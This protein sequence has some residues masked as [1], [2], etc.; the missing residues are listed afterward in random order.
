MPRKVSAA[1]ERKAK[2]P[3]LRPVRS[4]A[5]SS[6]QHVDCGSGVRLE[7]GVRL[8]LPDGIELVSDHY[9]PPGTDDG[10]TAPTLLVRQPYG[11]AIA[12]TV[13][14]AQPEWFARHGYNVVIQDVRGRGDSTGKFYPFRNEAGD[15]AFTVEWL[16]QRSETTGRVGMYGFSYQGMTQLLAAAEQPV[17]LTCIAPA[18]T[19]GDLYHGWFYH[20]GALRLAGTVGWAAQMLKTDARRLKLRKASDDLEAVWSK[21]PLLFAHAPYAK[22]SELNARGLPP[23]YHDWVTHREPDDYWAAHDVSRR[24]DRINVPGLHIAGWFDPYLLGSISLYE[25]L[26]AHAGSGHARANQ[27]LVAGPW[28]HIP[29]GR[30]AGE[31]DFGP[32]ANLDTDALLLRWF[33]HWLKDSG[34]FAK[35]PKAK[36]FA[37]GE[38][39]WHSLDEWPTQSRE[40][41]SSAPTKPLANAKSIPPAREEG[42]TGQAKRLSYFLR[43]AGFANSSKGD[44]ILDATAPPT[45]EPRDSFC[46][47][48][49]V[50]VPSPGNGAP[51]QFNQTRAELLNN[52]LIYTG[53][54]VAERLHICGAPRVILFAQTSA[55]STDLVAKL[56]RVTPDGRA[57]NVCL[58]IARSGFLFRDR[59]H[60]PDTPQRWEFTLEPTSCVFAPGERLRLE[61]CSSAFP[62]YDRHP[63]CDV[64]PQRATSWDWRQARTQILH[65]AKHPS[66]L[67]L[68]VLA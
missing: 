17:G 63:N 66:S 60:Q 23:Y 24:Y 36:L 37:Q 27:F 6:G 45:D 47:E 58:G 59:P 10:R 50:P 62:L 25:S 32:A 5:A 29:W 13:T 53:V 64:P 19:A 20:H 57:L 12:T 3:S 39:R 15:G 8:R 31:T 26:V 52:V 1:R 2:K 18:Q 7:R 41:V 14:Y 21:L 16:A 44:G 61:I 46:Y 34:E 40:C 30:F 9:Y 33:N 55:L 38:N 11:R 67:E 54:Q 49:E 68:P 56:I 28:V 22:I 51:G 48:P 65:D 35:E 42:A 4:L 43:S